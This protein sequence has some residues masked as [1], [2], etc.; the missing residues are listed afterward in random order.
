MGMWTD[1]KGRVYIAVAAERLVVRVAADGK[2]SVVA[3]SSAPWSPSG[4]MVD[5]DGKLWLLEYDA[6]NKVRA[7]QIGNDGHDRV[8]V[9][10][11]PQGA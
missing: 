8:F 9:A 1:T 5:R 6:N 3:H 4:G 2:P 7:R 11:S 10:E